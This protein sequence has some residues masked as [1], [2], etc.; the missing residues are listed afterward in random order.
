MEQYRV[1]IVL[2][3]DSALPLQR[4]LASLRAR[5]ALQNGRI[6]GLTLSVDVDPLHML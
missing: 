2:F 6:N 1:E 4:L 3:S 5:G